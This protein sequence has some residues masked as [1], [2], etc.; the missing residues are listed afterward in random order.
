MVYAVTKNLANFF[1]YDKLDFI[2]REAYPTFVNDNVQTV[3][4]IKSDSSF[5]LMYDFSA[6]TCW[7]VEDPVYGKKLAD[8]Y[9]GDNLASMMPLLSFAQFYEYDC[10]DFSVYGLDHPQMIVRVMYHE[11]IQ[12]ENQESQTVERNLVLSV[13]DYDEA[14]YYYVR[15]N[16]SNE[17]H[18]IAE[19]HI[20]KLLNET[21]VDYWVLNMAEVS[22][23]DLSC[24]EVEYGGDHY[25]LKKVATENTTAYYVND[26][27]ANA[28]LFEQFY[29]AAIGIE[30]QERKVEL[31]V[32]EE[33]EVT[34][35]FYSVYDE[36]VTVSY[37]PWDENF[38]A[39]VN[40]ETDF[41]LVNKM[42]IKD[43]ISLFLKVV[44]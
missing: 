24:V 41:G 38:Y 31:P 43:L 40:N 25:V 37:I 44:E 15:M 42:K 1:K 32:T 4:V 13:G 35:R 18:G 16:D 14:G 29:R 6:T 23:H 7:M 28:D 30:C 22:L 2:A 34:L 39:V 12:D 27:E 3:E 11:T 19:K 5:K 10:Q 20:N 8:E 17:V 21:V 26:V 36:D 9:E 33:A